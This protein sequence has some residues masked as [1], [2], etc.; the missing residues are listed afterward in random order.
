MGSRA[1]RS[2]RRALLV[3]LAAVALLTPATPALAGTQ[4]ADAAVSRTVT[5]RGT[6]V[7]VPSDWPVR[8]VDG[9]PGCVRFD[10]HAVYL[11]DPS[12][13]TC[14]PHLVG[15]TEAVQLTT[16]SLQGVVAPDRVVTAPGSPVG[17]VVS[18]GD[19]AAQARVIADSVTY[20]DATPEVTAPSGRRDARTFAAVPPTAAT[21]T[22]ASSSASTAASPSSTNDTTYAGLGFDACTAQPLSTMAAWY[23]A[24]PYK[25]ANMYMG[26]ASRGCSQP[27]LTADWVTQTVAQGWTLFPTYVGLQASCSAFPNRID[28]TQAAAQGSAAA[29]D[30]VAQLNALGLGIGNPVYFD[31]EAFSYTNTTCLAATRA[32]LDAWTVQLHNRGYVSGLYSSSN[33]LAAIVL[34]GGAPSAAIHQ[35]DDIWFA[36]WPSDSS[37]PGDPTLSDVAIP[38]QY[39]ADHQRIHQYH[40]GHTET[41]GGI[42][43]NIDNDSLDAAVAPSQLAAD[44]TF[45]TISGQGGTYRMAGGAPIPV[46]DWAAVGGEQPVTTLS[47]T[48]FAS[49][50]Q[51]PQT[52]TF[53][54]SGATGRIWRVANGI[55]AYLPSWTPYGGPKPSILIDQAALDNAGLG[56]V[57]NHLASG[58]P[59]PRMTGP[60]TPGTSA[61]KVRFTWFGGY[62]SS[63]VSTFDVRYRTA[64]WNGTYGPWTRPT[65]WQ[66]TAATGEPLGVKTGHTSCVSVRARNKAGRLSAWSPQRCSARSLDDRALTRSSAWTAKTGS[67]YLGRTFVTTTTKNATLTRTSAKVKRVGVVASTC[68]TCGKVAVLVDGKRVGTINLA[69][70]YQ[71]SAVV[72]GPVFALHKAT[73]TLKV[74][75]SGARVRI[76]GVV[77]SRS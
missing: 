61:G 66:R 53:L 43:V 16:R 51:R 17:V 67:G 65:S 46:T 64:A 13:S 73:I 19:G 30:A 41:W 35:P 24:S 49:L 57:W 44:G 59:A 75:S 4:V 34:D 68:R 70:A 60:E 62:S 42:A 27:N 74:R 32:F 22:T 56:G 39:W 54:Q 15:R 10:Q 69:G 2:G 9:Q 12:R 37:Q 7:T 55:A 28:P 33:T 21:G 5:F 20:A 18:A 45:V 76:D 26:G 11:G 58:T 1:V 14:P 63:A 50:P 36:R 72:M 47:P 29:D 3:G 71:R 40:G 8:R 38:D 25:A 6:S 23:A 77:L 52:G 48:Q 31:M